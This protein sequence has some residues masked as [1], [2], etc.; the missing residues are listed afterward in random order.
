VVVLGVA[1]TACRPI[2]KSGGAGSGLRLTVL[3][4]ES[5]S[6]PTV[7]EA[8][9][10]SMT[11]VPIM[12]VGER[13]MSK[14][15]LE[16]VQLSIEC[17]DSTDECYRAVGSEL[18]AN[19]LLFADVERARERVKVKVFMF[20]VDA[21]VISGVAEREFADERSAQEGVAA[22]VENAASGGKPVP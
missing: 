2:A 22:L 13:A 20:D 6:F 5:D 18:A 21:G 3:P 12:G 10:R 11:T 4:A 15:S 7:A 16:V 1:L 19:R 14:V 8:L 9:N 17:V